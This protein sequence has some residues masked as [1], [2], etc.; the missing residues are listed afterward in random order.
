MESVRQLLLAAERGH[1]DDLQLLLNYPNDMLPDACT[2]TGRTALHTAALHNHTS[3]ADVLL[4]KGAKIDFADQNCTTALHI[5]A[6]NGNVACITLLIRRGANIN[7]VTRVRPLNAR[8]WA[9][10]RPS[11]ALAHADPPCRAVSCRA[12]KA[13]T[14]FALACQGGSAESARIL[15]CTGCHVPIGTTMMDEYR[16]QAK[17]M[18][19]KASWIKTKQVLALLD[20]L[21]KVKPPDWGDWFRNEWPAVL[22]DIDADHKV[23]KEEF[24]AIEMAMQHTMIAREQAM[25]M[26]AAS[27]AQKR[28]RLKAEAAEAQT[29]G[30]AEAAAARAQLRR[31]TEE[32]EAAERASQEARQARDEAER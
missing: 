3:C 1:A 10:A 13:K 5:A 12:Q 17:F 16:K 4:N 7:A 28:N 24:K 11:R 25:K 27:Q 29:R 2:S 22:S 9:C 19:R 14:P 20:N 18:D 32:Q 15:A 8:C 21:E 30:E 31:E 26:K 23:E 6:L